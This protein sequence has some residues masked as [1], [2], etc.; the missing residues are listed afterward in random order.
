MKS[1]KIFA[2]GILLLCTTWISG[3]IM[4]AADHSGQNARELYIT[5]W[6]IISE[7]RKNGNIKTTSDQISEKRNNGEP[8]QSNGEGNE[9][10]SPIQTS[11]SEHVAQYHIDV[12][13]DA[14][15]KKLH[16]AQIVAWQ[17]PGGQ[18]LTELYLH[19]YPNAFRSK[20]TT[21]I[22]E[23]GGKLRQDTMAKNSYGH[24][25]I[26]SIKTD[27]G[28]DLTHRTT[29]VQ[30]DDGNEH[31]MTLM[32]LRLPQPLMPGERISLHLQFEVALPPVF[33]RMGYADDFIMAG[34]WFPKMAAYERQ[35]TRGRSDEG[36][37][38]HQY[39]GN[40]EFYANFAAY[41]VRIHVPA[42]YVVAATGFP[43]K[44]PTVKDGQKTYYFYADDVHDFAWSAS[45]HFEYFERPFSTPHVPGVLIKL[46]LDPTHAPLKDRYFH[47]AERSLAR[48][49]EWFGSY[50][51]ATLSIV[52]PPAGGS[53]AGG[54]EYPTLIT[55]WA[56]DDAQPDYELERVIVHEIAHQY[57]YGIVASNEF[58]EAWLDEAFAS[59]A[60]DKLLQTEYGIKTNSPIEASYVTSPAPLQQHA[61]AYDNHLHYAENVYV[62]GKLILQ[63]IEQSV[64]SAKMEEVLR[65]YFQRW[66]FRHPGTNDFQAV[67]EEVTGRSW[68]QYFDDFV[69]G[70]EMV[71]FSVESIQIA[72]IERDGV[73]KFEST[74]HMKSRGPSHHGTS[75]LFHFADGKALSKRWNRAENELHI[76]LIHDAPV[77]WVM[78]DPDYELVLEHKQINNFKKTHVERQSKW[79]WQFGI[80]KMIETFIGSIAW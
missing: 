23:S 8:E 38:L 25:V 45:P 70:G 63:D 22:R 49:S 61:W 6:G 60:E 7:I 34:Q 51:Y 62:R 3:L 44:Q 16:G 31:D 19:L 66:Q 57:F 28:V 72:K 80:L 68:Q 12:T 15:Q 78:I 43:V 4:S 50:P 73:P 41:I 24:M 67:L 1:K 42:D 35:G 20:E 46:Y 17:H 64:G 55:A 75:V 29:F 40:S 9:E 76:K 65:R 32:Q 77:D 27:E 69:Y 53:G 30:P 33:A 54:M 71:D 10:Q 21:F 39:H 59:Y 79:R 36:W 37:N 52:V 13:L 18:P 26:H 47:A 56:A 11:L 48:F 14:E 58:E 74:V 2:L 5:E